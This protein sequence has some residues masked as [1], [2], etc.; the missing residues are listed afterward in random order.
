M[1][2][3]SKGQFDPPEPQESVHS[4]YQQN[5]QAGMTAKE[6]AKDAQVRTGL[7][8]VTGQRIKDKTGSEYISKYKTKGLKYRGQFG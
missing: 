1:A 3:S 6:A 7:S 8:L 5:L 4:V 2:G